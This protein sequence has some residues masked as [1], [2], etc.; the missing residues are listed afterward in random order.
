MVDIKHYLDKIYKITIALSYL[1]DK[2]TEFPHVVEALE[3]ALA[4]MEWEFT[5][6]EE[7]KK[8]EKTK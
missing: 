2:K 7:K 6:E 3:Q 4:R 1:T 5:P 8:I